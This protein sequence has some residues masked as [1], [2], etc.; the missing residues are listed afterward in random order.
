M[1]EQSM[2]ETM[3]R[4][5]CR[6]VQDRTV[7]EELRASE[8]WQAHREITVERGWRHYEPFAKDAIAAMRD[9]PPKIAEAHRVG[10][11][12]TWTDPWGCLGPEEEKALGLD[13]ADSGMF[14]PAHERIDEYMLTAWHDAIDTM[15][16][17][18]KSPLG[19][20]AS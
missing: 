7:G 15:L 1:S 19:S 4:A 14:D 18:P 3:A 20:T 5:M 16:G 2:I 9:L 6:G 11:L 13:V 17:L 12:R 8:P 10:F